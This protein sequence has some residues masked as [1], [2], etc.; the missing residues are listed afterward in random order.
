MAL[1]FRIGVPSGRQDWSCSSA[2]EGTK[3]GGDKEAP[4]WSKETRLI[5]LL[6][7][8]MGLGKL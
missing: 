8:W 4:R 5:G 6:K 7:V 2:E 1:G 3:W